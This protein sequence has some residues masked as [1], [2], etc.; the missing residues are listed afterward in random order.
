MNEQHATEGTSFDKNSKTSLVVVGV[1]AMPVGNTQ[2]YP[3][4]KAV[5]V[6]DGYVQSPMERLPGTFGAAFHVFDVPQDARGRSRPA[7]MQY[8][9]F[10]VPPGTYRL[11]GITTVAPMAAAKYVQS[12]APKHE[13]VVRAGEAAYIGNFMFTRLGPF[14]PDY[15]LASDNIKGNFYG[16]FEAFGRDDAAARQMLARYASASVVMQD[17]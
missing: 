4:V 9:V 7:P 6:K 16:N 2:E 12:T 17:R 11:I 5:W 8:R 15:M 14:V 10:E 13:F 3:T 1:T